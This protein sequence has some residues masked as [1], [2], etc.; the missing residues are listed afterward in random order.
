MHALG[1]T[2]DERQAYLELII[3]RA[4]ARCGSP[5]G[6]EIVI[7]YP[8]DSRAMLAEHAHSERA[9]IAGLDFGKDQTAWRQ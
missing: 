9:A 7:E 1:I 2:R 3:G 5:A 6:V 8:S 4:M